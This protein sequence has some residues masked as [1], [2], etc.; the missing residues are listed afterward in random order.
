MATTLWDFNGTFAEACKAEIVRL[1]T[2][3]AEATDR[4]EK[5]QLNGNDFQV[6]QNNGLI[7]K[8]E[9]RIAEI[10]GLWTNL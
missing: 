1:Q 10:E 5:A 8:C 4:R 7:E 6:A 2:G 3:I 9:K